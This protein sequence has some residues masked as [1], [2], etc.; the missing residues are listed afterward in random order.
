M[1]DISWNRA[2]FKAFMKFPIEVRER[3]S[4]GLEA[5][6]QGKF[7]EI[8]KPLKGFDSGVYELAM[9]HRGNAWRTVYALKI[10]DDVWVLH[11]FQKKST[12]GIKTSKLDIDLIE[13]RLSLLRR[14]ANG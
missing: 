3:M 2:A 6:L 12:E 8:A 7:P 11:A 5:V 13:T 10:D 4:A 1:R 9:R 14:N